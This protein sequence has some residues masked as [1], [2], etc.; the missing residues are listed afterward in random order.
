MAI[1][2]PTASAAKEKAKDNVEFVANMPTEEVF[3]APHRLKVDGVVKS[4]KPLIHNGQII[5]GFSIT[6]K[7]GKV[8]DYSAEKGYYTLKGLI[9]TDAGTKSIGE[10]ALI[11]KN[12]PIAKSGVLF[13]NTL[14]YEYICK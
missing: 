10:V 7:K 13:Y 4:T 9:E 6:F 2:L 3:T 14:L 12:S 5:D 1:T 11:G 8:V